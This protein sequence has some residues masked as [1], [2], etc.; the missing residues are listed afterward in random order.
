MT[1]ATTVHL[2]FGP[3]GAGKTSYARTIAESHCAVRFSIDEWMI[4]L[5]GPDLPKTMSMSWVTARVRRCEGRIWTTAS[6]IARLGVSVVLDVGLMHVSDRKRFTALARE[7]GLGCQLHF[8]DAPYSVR[9]SRVLARNSERGETFAF[10]VTPQVFDFMDKQFESPTDTELADAV[11][12][13]FQELKPPG[14]HGEA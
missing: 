2:V 7:A 3:Q 14:D 12:A 5:F 10:E 11:V 1:T 8:V 4:E 6:Q 9:R 13:P